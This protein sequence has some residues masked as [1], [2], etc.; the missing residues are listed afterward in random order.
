MSWPIEVRCSG[1]RAACVFIQ[2][3][4]HACLYSLERQ[5][6]NYV[7]L[8][9]DPA[10]IAFGGSRNGCFRICENVRLPPAAINLLE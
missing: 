4:R 9:A 8:R 6:D 3:S 1:R 10:Q 2:S 5:G 7:T